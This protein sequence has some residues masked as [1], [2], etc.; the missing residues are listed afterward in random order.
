M[1]KIGLL[2]TIELEII[3]LYMVI[4]PVPVESLSEKSPQVFI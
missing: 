3:E 2:L 4:M 1:C